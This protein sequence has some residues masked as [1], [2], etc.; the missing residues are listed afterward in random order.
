[1][2]LVYFKNRHGQVTEIDVELQ[3]TM[4]E[5]VKKIEELGGIEKVRINMIKYSCSCDNDLTEILLD[6]ISGDIS[7]NIQNN[8]DK[9]TEIN[10]TYHE[11]NIKQIKGC[12]KRIKDDSELSRKRFEILETKLTT[13]ISQLEGS[14]V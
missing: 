4:R 3:E 7:L 2:T 13:R 11:L 12:C 1:M 5:V 14:D 6:D 9:S 8:V 10:S